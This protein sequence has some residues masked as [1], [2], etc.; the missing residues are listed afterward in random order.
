MGMANH[1][2]NRGN[3]DLDAAVE[4]YSK[5][6]PVVVRSPDGGLLHGQETLEVIVSVGVPLECCV[7]RNISVDDFNNSDWPEVLEAARTVFMERG[8]FTIR[9]GPKQQP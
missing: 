6:I 1:G 9:E 7:I 8:G 5:G 2:F 4:A 3:L